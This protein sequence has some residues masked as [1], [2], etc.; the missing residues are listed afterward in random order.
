MPQELLFT[1]RKAKLGFP[2][3]SI[4]T[5]EVHSTGNLVVAPV[6]GGSAGARNLRL[7]LVPAWWKS[8][9]FLF[10]LSAPFHLASSVANLFQTE[11]ID[12][13]GRRGPDLS[14]SWGAACCRR[15][16]ECYK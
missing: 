11:A 4:Y 3:V 2:L 9:S 7:A 1:S 16:V 6:P 8:E 15:R 5:D 13:T 12:E 14:K 10:P